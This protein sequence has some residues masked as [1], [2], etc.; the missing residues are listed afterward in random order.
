M[1][2]VAAL[3]EEDG[4]QGHSAS[5]GATV[6]ACGGGCRERF[7]AAPLSSGRLCVRS[8]NVLKDAM[9]SGFMT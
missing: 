7:P 3:G 4:Q 5:T 6:A 1:L 9:R 2:I 8:S